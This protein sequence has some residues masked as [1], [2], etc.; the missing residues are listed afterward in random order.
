MATQPTQPPIC[1]YLFNT[2]LN[3]SIKNNANSIY[4]LSL[5][6]VI[7]SNSTISFNTDF[8]QQLTD[9]SNAY[10]YLYNNSTYIQTIGAS[11]FSISFLVSN[12]SSTT[13]YGL[14]FSLYNS[15]SNIISFSIRNKVYLLSIRINNINF[16]FNENVTTT[17]THY[18]IT[19]DA[20]NKTMRVYINGNK[21]QN[22]SYNTSDSNTA[23]G[24]FTFATGGE[25]TLTNAFSTTTN[26]TLYIL[27]G[28]SAYNLSW[29]A[30]NGANNSSGAICT[31]QRFYLYNYVLSDYN[32]SYL[33]NQTS[34]P[35][36]P[37]LLQFK[38]NG[39]L[40]NTGTNTSTTAS[41]INTTD[42]S[43]STVDT[44]YSYGTDK[45]LWFKEYSY[46]GSANVRGLRIDTPPL[47]Y[48][49]AVGFHFRYG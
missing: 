42:C 21:K 41:I 9:S 36:P 45:S 4:D 17:L 27:G 6:N 33:Y 31:L 23:S 28:P 24:A 2:Y 34:P 38:L 26:T 30:N 18:A 8:I 37:P 39:N 7:T 15:N 3:N 1:E 25:I 22:N 32:I 12:Y 40:T 29:P 16:Y 44:I 10:S 35:P 14:V 20:T 5:T 43:F 49:V 48:Q 11:S 19:Y 47:H 46:S 13:N